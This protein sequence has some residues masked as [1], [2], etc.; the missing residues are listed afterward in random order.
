MTPLLDPAARLVIAHRGASADA[1]ENTLEAFRLAVTQGCDAIELD[2]RLTRDGVAVVLHDPTLSRTTDRA[3]TLEDLTFGELQS[4]DAGAGY[5]ASDGTRPFAGKGI[6][7]PRL[8][9][10]LEEFPD[11]PFLIEIKAPESQHAVARDLE[12]ANAAG[13][14]VIA[15][16]S[17]GAL[18]VIRRDLF[19]V[20]AS[21]RDVMTLYTR[22]CLGLGI[23]PPRCRCYAVP[24]RWRN[25]IEVPRRAFIAEARRH[26]RPVHVWTVDDPAIAT[27][28]WERGASGIISN[29]PGEIRK[30]L[31]A[32]EQLRLGPASQLEDA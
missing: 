22:T 13:R 15:A 20:G 3:G 30:A 6:R 8:S 17:R 32:L 9:H 5:I 24:W 26:D 27:L 28:L 10:L 18:N 25:R 1:P 2:V 31:Q 16:F 19:L 14:A 4:V 23:A 11:L 21:R 12:R 7:I 29:R